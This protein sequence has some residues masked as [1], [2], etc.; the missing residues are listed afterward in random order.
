VVNFNKDSYRIIFKIGIGQTLLTGQTLNN[1]IKTKNKGERIMKKEKTVLKVCKCCSGGS[2]FHWDYKSTISDSV[3][4][5]KLIPVWVCNNC[6]R[7]KPYKG[8]AKSFN[9]HFKNEEF[10]NK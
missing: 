1:L 6:S 7:I 3:L 10:F 9:E 2:Y 4:D 8:F 5:M